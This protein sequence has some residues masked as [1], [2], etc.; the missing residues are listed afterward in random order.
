MDETAAAAAPLGL[1]VNKYAGTV[2][3]L[4]LEAVEKAFA[5]IDAASKASFRS[6]TRLTVE[7]LFLWPAIPGFL[8][9]L[10]AVLL[11]APRANMRMAAA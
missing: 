8:L 5:A 7:E 1:V 10:L 11:M 9:L 3:R 6:R 2:R 4:G